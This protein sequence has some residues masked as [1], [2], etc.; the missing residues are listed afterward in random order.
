MFLEDYDLNVARYLVQGVD[1]WLNTPRRP[2]EAS[3]TSG[4][5]AV[6]NGGLH[7]STLDGWWDEAFRPGAGLGDRRP[8]RLSRRRSSRTRST[9]PVCSICSSARS[10]RC[11]TSATRMACRVAGSPWC[12]P[13]WPSFHRSSAPSAWSAEYDAQYYRPAQPLA[14]RLA[15]SSPAPVRR[16]AAWLA[17][18]EPPGRG[19]RSSSSRLTRPAFGLAHRFA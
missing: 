8:A 5:K 11:S 6:A 10:C 13:H 17:R 3:G 14:T 12:A 9:A 19:C 2:L 18:F 1:V 15:G 16:L 7:L 4:M